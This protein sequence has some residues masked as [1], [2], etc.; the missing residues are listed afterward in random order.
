MHGTNGIG[1][2]QPKSYQPYLQRGSIKEEEYPQ[3]DQEIDNDDD[4]D[5][6]PSI[7]VSTFPRSR[8]PN[9]QLK[10]GTGNLHISIGTDGDG[11]SSNFYE[12]RQRRVEENKKREEM[13]H[14]LRDGTENDG[15]RVSITK[16]DYVQEAE[17][18]GGSREDVTDQKQGAI[19]GYNKLKRMDSLGQELNAKGL[20]SV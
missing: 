12:E 4:D 10:I 6:R 7:C 16:L 8:S 20:L 1:M 5:N 14:L 17:G 2:N 9:L 3:N 18:E 19:G 13:K 11:P 15:K